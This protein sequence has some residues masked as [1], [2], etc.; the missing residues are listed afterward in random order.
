[1][2][3]IFGSYDAPAPEPEFELF[4]INPTWKRKKVGETTTI[5]TPEGQAS[6]TGPQPGPRPFDPTTF[7]PGSSVRY[8]NAQEFETTPG[9]IAATKR[10]TQLGQLELVKQGLTEQLLTHPDAQRMQQL[11]NLQMLESFLETGQMPGKPTGARP[12]VSAETQTYDAW[13]NKFMQ[14]DGLSRPDAQLKAAAKLTDLRSGRAGNE[15]FERG[16]EGIA[17]KLAPVPVPG[18][19]G[20]VLP[21]MGAVK[22]AQNIAN[23]ISQGLQGPSKPKWEML[24]GA[25]RQTS[26]VGQLYRPAFVG[27]GFQSFLGTMQQAV[28]SQEGHPTD[29]TWN[30]TPGGLAG[31]V[32]QFF[33]DITP[34]EA[35]FRKGVLDVSDMLL[36]ARSGAQ[37]NEQE[38]RRLTA[39]LFNLTD[40]PAVFEP[41]WR[42]FAYEIGAMMDDVVRVSTTPGRK[43]PPGT[44]AKTQLGGMRTVKTP[45]EAA[46]LPPGTVYQTPDGRK[47]RR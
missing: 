1:M 35:T 34:E 9:A 27:K 44:A 38:Y 32:R 46:A 23:L 33:G 25:D 21:G 7:A 5:E 22:Y 20:L 8:P 16:K 18:E 4:G 39:L 30:Y 19:P 41:A 6:F 24:S 42:R 17:G 26:L 13:V 10:G 12:G 37:I 40:E 15:A 11:A 31:A 28:Q 14:D 43:L 36:R 45:A 29:E 2:P 47:F 3:D